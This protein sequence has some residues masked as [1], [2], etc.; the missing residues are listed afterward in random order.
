MNTS[1]YIAL[2]ALLVSLF[3]LFV[4]FSTKFSEF[5]KAS[6]GNILQ[7]IT[8]LLAITGGFL[9]VYIWAIDGVQDPAIVFCG[10]MIFIF[11]VGSV[12]V[13]E[14]LRSERTKRN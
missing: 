6:W 4:A 3:A 11:L 12:F 14:A 10:G 2:A 1:D 5:A 7:F 8:G 13:I 9:M